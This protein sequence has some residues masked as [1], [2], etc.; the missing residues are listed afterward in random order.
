MKNLLMVSILI[1]M[2]LGTAVM[3]NTQ[4]TE[5]NTQ[6]QQSSLSNRNYSIT[7]EE[8]AARAEAQQNS[9]MRTRKAFEINYIDS[10][11]KSWE[12]YTE[13]YQKQKKIR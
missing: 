10:T 3:A 2:V 9:W 1:S 12:E 6:Q 13:A 11:K 5:E 8:W 4:Y 7:P